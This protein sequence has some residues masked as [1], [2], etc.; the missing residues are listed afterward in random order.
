MLQHAWKCLSCSIED[1]D[2]GGGQCDEGFLASCSEFVVLR[3]QCLCYSWYGTYRKS[4]F[5]NIT[6]IKTV[7]KHDMCS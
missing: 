7:Q 6:K 5:K 2:G 3:V 4:G 1:D